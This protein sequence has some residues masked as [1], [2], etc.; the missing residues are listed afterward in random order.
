MDDNNNI[1]KYYSSIDNNTLDNLC[2]N[3]DIRNLINLSTYSDINVFN[4]RKDKYKIKNKKI[5]LKECENKKNESI[6]MLSNLAKLNINHDNINNK[7]D[8]INKIMNCLHKL[9]NDEKYIE[10]YSND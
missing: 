1:N 3:N 5:L 7:L 6:L 10:C 4:K 9:N 2:K 8:N